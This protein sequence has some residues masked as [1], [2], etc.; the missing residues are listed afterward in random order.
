MEGGELLDRIL[1]QKFLNER[2]ASAVLEVIASTIK[3]LHDNGV[4]ILIKGILLAF[5]V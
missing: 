1:S 3:Y 2:E 4:L 5:I